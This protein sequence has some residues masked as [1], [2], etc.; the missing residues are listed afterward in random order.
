[1]N[2]SQNRGNA[3]PDHA[4]AGHDQVGADGHGDERLHEERGDDP[5]PVTTIAR[6]PASSDFS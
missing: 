1:M 6:T 3:G 4:R 5:D 2:F